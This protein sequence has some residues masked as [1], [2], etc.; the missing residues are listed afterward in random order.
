MLNRQTEQSMKPEEGSHLKD[1]LT[2]VELQELTLLVGSRKGLQIYL[3]MERKP[4]DELWK[5]HSL[6]APTDYVRSLTLEMISSTLLE[7]GSIEKLSTHYGVSS[8]FLKSHL[9]SVTSTL[10]PPPSKSISTDGEWL[11]TR[12]KSVRLAAR[13]SGF[14]EGQI[15]KFVKERKLEHLLKYDFSNHNNA[16]GRRAETYWASLHGDK[17]LEDCNVT[18]GSQA[19]YD[20]VHSELGKVNV[21]SSKAHR[22]TAKTRKDNPWYWKVSSTGLHKASTIALVLYDSRMQQP[23]HVFELPV[24]EEMAKASSIRLQIVKGKLV[25]HLTDKDAE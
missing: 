17:I 22:Y 10:S 1:Y 25:M 9:Q 7:V 21:K 15:R 6:M 16:K 5:K 4:F 11:V 12:Y 8:S 19:D 18:Q 14:T 13:M 2:A 24:T 3:G 20:Y 23:L